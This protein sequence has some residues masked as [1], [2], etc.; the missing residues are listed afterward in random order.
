MGHLA[1][2]CLHL[3]VDKFSRPGVKKEAGLLELELAQLS[4]VQLQ[5]SFR[6][7]PILNISTKHCFLR[8]GILA[9][10]FIRDALLVCI[11]SGT[12]ALDARNTRVQ[13]S[14]VSPVAGCVPTV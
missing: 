8:E 10:G 14:T 1:R 9:P 6:W 5:P 2:R 3:V 4:F 13:E 7:L 12:R 11:L